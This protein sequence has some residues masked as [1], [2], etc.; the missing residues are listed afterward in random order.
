MRLIVK[1]IV[2]FGDLGR[3]FFFSGE[4]T[5]ID[6]VVVFDEVDMSSS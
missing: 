1:T 4:V 6:L 2:S 3:L 5:T